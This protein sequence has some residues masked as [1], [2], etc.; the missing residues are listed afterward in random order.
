MLTK[1]HGAAPLGMGTSLGD[2]S[3]EYPAKDDAFEMV[4]RERVGGFGRRSRAISSALLFGACS[5]ALVQFL[6]PAKLLLFCAC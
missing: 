1:R 5:H 2:L 3:R 4:I 6:L